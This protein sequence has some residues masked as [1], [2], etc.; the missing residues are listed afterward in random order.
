MWPVGS[1]SPG[2]HKQAGGA[3][4]VLP[5][6]YHGL[7][8]AR[9]GPGARGPA[10]CTPAAGPGSGCRL[11]AA[12]DSQERR[13]G[14]C[15]TSPHT[16]ELPPRCAPRCLP[17]PPVLR[18]AVL[19]PQPPAGGLRTPVVT[20][21]PRMNPVH[22][23]RLPAL[24]LPSQPALVRDDASYVSSA[25]EQAA[26][27]AGGCTAFEVDG[28]SHSPMACLFAGGELYDSCCDATSYASTS[29][30]PASLDSQS[31]SVA[32]GSRHPSLDAPGRD[33]QASRP[34]MRRSPSSA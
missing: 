24:A 31:Q 26:A 4:P 33:K 17:P 9:A 22:K 7:P 16:R 10:V 3:P 34:P 2:A 19:K 20:P 8:R 1:E 29:D 28:P 15:R 32:L 21:V 14:L 18:P 25:G 12:P 11:W 6:A 5:A 30:F 13:T 23:T 27:R